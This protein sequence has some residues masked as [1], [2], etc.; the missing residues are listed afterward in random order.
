MK[1]MIASL[2]DLPPDTVVVGRGYEDG[3]DDVA[4]AVLF[5]V[6]DTQGPGK[7]SAWWTGRYD[8]DR[9][10]PKIAVAVIA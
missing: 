9:D 8:D 2:Q 3:Y 1:E 5:E 6:V 7:K 10:G 4:P